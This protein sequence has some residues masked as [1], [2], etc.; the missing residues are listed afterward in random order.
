[1]ICSIL[2]HPPVSGAQRRTMKLL[3]AIE[4]AG[5]RPHVIVSSS[6]EDDEAAAAELRARGWGVDLN[7]Q[8]RSTASS[9]LRQHVRRLPSPYVPAIEQRLRELG[10]GDTA[11]V[12]FEHAQ[13]SY[14]GSV[15][16][17][18][19]VVLSTHNVDAE[20]ISSLSRGAPPLAPER[21]RLRFR[22]GS[23]LRTERRAARA[24]DAVLCV[25]EHD[26]AEF[27]RLGGARVLVVPNG[28]D[29]ELF[30][31]GPPPED[32]ESVLFFGLMAYPPNVQGIS[33]FVREGWPQVARKRP[34]SVLRVV[35]AG[36]SPELARALGEGERVEFAGV[37][38]DI[39]V[40]LARAN[41]V[42]VPIWQGAGTR[43][44]V[45]E[46]MAAARPVVGTPL[47]VERIGFEDGEH[48]LVDE[49]PGGL[50][51]LTS[52]LLADQ[53]RA[54]EL[55]TQGRSLA[56]RFR[57]RDVVRPAEELYRGWVGRA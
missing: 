34:R 9:R 43:L 20:L 14:Y 21:W 31:I 47:G 1:M 28:V 48:G 33:R 17:S 51:R 44:K 50:A 39:S 27:R 53:A 12:Q 38:P 24:A 2:P 41:V 26:A 7:V 25:S 16:P 36:A 46:S 57:W 4:R 37:V 11:F 56:R 30:D 10:A 22:A 19:P 40:E 6:G 3:E 55:G 5:A 8:P 45:L 18:V 15:L 49:D 29:D 32:T 54:T 13:N 23:M 35:G 42:V 52:E